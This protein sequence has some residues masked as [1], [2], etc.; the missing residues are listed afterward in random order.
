MSNDRG[1]RKN[2]VAPGMIS[3]V[4]GIDDVLDRDHK[5]G[6]YEIAYARCL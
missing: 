5:L 3:M 6:L 2:A 4:M 1:I